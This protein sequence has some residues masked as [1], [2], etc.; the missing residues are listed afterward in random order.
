[1]SRAAVSGERVEA[2][3]GAC[4]ATGKVAATA[5]ST[6]GTRDPAV[7]VSAAGGVPGKSGVSGQLIA[8]LAVVGGALASLKRSF[9]AVGAFATGRLA[10]LRRWLLLRLPQLALAALT[11]WLVA[12]WSYQYAISPRSQAQ[13]AGPVLI[14]LGVILQLINPNLTSIHEFYRER[15]SSA[16]AVGRDDE[17]PPVASN[18]PYGTCYRLSEL[19]PEP[20]LVLCT[21]AN[22]ND[23]RVVPTRRF[24][25]PLT[26][27]PDLVRLESEGVPPISATSPPRRSRTTRAGRPCR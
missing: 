17:S 20:E 25:V 13:I 24:G 12:L 3:Y 27:S 1:M 7:A 23:Q 5:G 6:P 15:L 10:P 4:G 19:V 11:L 26:L 8:V 21:T 16:F 2:S 9:G 14:A 18:L 22:V